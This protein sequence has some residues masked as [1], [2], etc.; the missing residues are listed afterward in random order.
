MCLPAGLALPLSAVLF[1]ASG[2]AQVVPRAPFPGGP[3]ANPPPGPQGPAFPRGGW[4]NRNPAPNPGPIKPNDPGRFG[5]IEVIWKCSR[6]GR[7]LGRGPGG[8]NRT[9]P[10]CSRL[11][12]PAAAW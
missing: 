1:L 9:C 10:D 8:A 6:C 11:N 7:E 2:R 3:R 4:D 5:G 12:G